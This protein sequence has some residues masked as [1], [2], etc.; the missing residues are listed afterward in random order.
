[1]QAAAPPL[2]F[3]PKVV[4]NKEMN[5]IQGNGDMKLQKKVRF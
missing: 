1:M 3:L 4:A 5:C 2:K